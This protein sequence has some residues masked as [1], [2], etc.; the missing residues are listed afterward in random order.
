MYHQASL[1]TNA[2]ASDVI[3]VTPSNAM[4]YRR[5]VFSSLLRSINGNEV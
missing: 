3:N 4:F 1:E 2:I 5:M